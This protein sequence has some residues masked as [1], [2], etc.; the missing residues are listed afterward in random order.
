MRA[1]TMGKQSGRETRVFKCHKDPTPRKVR[2][3][4]KFL[5]EEENRNKISFY[6]VAS[7]PL[8]SAV[9]ALFFYNFRNE[10]LFSFDKLHFDVV[11]DSDDD[12]GTGGD[13]E[14]MRI[15]F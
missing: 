5:L 1:S 11:T 3:E 6:D 14:R 2:K 15:D 12:E 9:C 7:S 10:K 8:G 13:R 4:E